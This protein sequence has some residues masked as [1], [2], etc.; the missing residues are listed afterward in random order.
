MQERGGWCGGGEGF[1]E[2]ALAVEHLALAGDGYS[3]W[4]GEGVLP[5]L[6]AEL[7][8]EVWEEMEGSEGGHLGGL[9]R[10]D[11]PIEFVARI[12]TRQ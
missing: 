4:F 11:G 7:E 8:R 5:D 10:I 2:A 3:S 1:C 9:E 6:E 12:L